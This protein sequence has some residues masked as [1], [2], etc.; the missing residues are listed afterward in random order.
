MQQV[1][2]VASAGGVGRKGFATRYVKPLARAAQEGPPGGTERRISQR[3]LV[4]ML[5][6]RGCEVSPSALTRYLNGERRPE[7]DFVRGLHRLAADRSG[8]PT[9]AGI[10]WDVVAE[11]YGRLV[12]CKNCAALND[13]VAV[14]RAENQERATSL[15]ALAEE[16]AGLRTLARAV[17]RRAALAPVPPAEGDRRSESSDIAAARSFAATTAELHSSGRPE[18][19][20]AALADAV[21]FLTSEEAVAALEFLHSGRHTQ[22]EESF[23]HMVARERSAGT[24][25]EVAVELKERRMAALADAILK[26]AAV[27]AAVRGGWG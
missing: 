10:G 8:S 26:A 22:L 6:E 9:P 1:A 13:A 14:L 21:R 19:A 15:D 20:A 11:A 5:G 4:E 12:W 24:V 25:I 18:D 7:L 3:R 16:V 27:G 23:G 2:G 17:R